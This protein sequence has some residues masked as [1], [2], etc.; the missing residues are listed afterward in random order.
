VTLQFIAPAEISRIRSAVD[1]R[2]ERCRVTANASRLNALSMIAYAGSGH[3]GTSFSAMDVLCWL[4]TEVASGHARSARDDGDIYFSSKGHDVPG[5][6]AM[7]IGLGHLD[8]NGFTQLR[9]LDG[10]P[11][12]PDVGVPYMITNTGSLGMGISKARGLAIADR[13]DGRRRRLFVLTGDGELQEGQFWESL[14]PTANGKFS[15]I[16]VIVDHNKLQSDTFVG[17]VSDLGDLMRKIAS[18]GWAVARCDGHDPA[19]IEAALRSIEHSDGPRLL[20]ADTLKGKGVSVMEP[21]AVGPDRLYRFHSGAPSAQHYRLGITELERAINAVLDQHGITR[22]RLDEVP[23]PARFVA[24]SPDRL[25]PA[26]A[27]ELVALGREHP[28]L[29]VLD[30]DLVVDCGAHPFKLEFP[31]RFVECGIA[32]QDM[33]SMAGALALAGKLP[34]VH[35]FA[36]FLST[37]PNEQIYNAATE[38][39]KI[40]Y[41]A[42]LAGLLP[43]TPGHSHQSVRDISALGSVPNLV[44]IQPSTAA[45]TRKALRWAVETNP[46]STYLRLTSIPVAIPFELPADYRLELG[47]GTEIKPGRDGAIIAYGPVMLAQAYLAAQQLEARGRSLAVIDLPWLNRIDAGWLASVVQAKR[48]LYLVEDHYPQLGQSAFITQALCTNGIAIPTRIYGVEEIPQCGQIPEILARHRLD[49]A[50]L[51]DRISTDD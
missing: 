38:H 31:T 48:R 22:V 36:C 6:Y 15:E 12:H 46:A 19:A 13:L 26:Y 8:A 42:S 39:T 28:E 2:Y 23:A 29:V 21:N 11:G 37:R 34:I 1:D 47:R 30:A 4:W 41:H 27:E 9:R 35:S 7:L 20:I 16:T 44:L 10:L 14:Q 25:I 43:A 49:A 5:L 18:F 40:I 45:A 3:V 33:V 17:D 24:E 51:A 50:S 32:E